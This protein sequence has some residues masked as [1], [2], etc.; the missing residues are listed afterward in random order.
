MIRLLLITLLLPLYSMAQSVDVN[1]IDSGQD[2]TTIEIRK[3]K[4]EDLK[5]AGWEVTDGESDIE[6]ESSATGRDADKA[7]KKACEDWK[8]EFRADNKDNKILN[9]NCGT[10]TCS[11]DA[12][13][14]VC[15]S[16]ATYKI[17]TRVD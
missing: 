1:N 12:G 2:T 16:K 11:G 5:T 13:S 7:W 8:K 10:K 17:K 9:L 4:K 6:G 14:K 3:G 15:V